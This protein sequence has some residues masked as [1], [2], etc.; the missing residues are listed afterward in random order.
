MIKRILP[1]YLTGWFYL[2]LLF[3][4]AIFC[5]ISTGGLNPANQSNLKLLEKIT[6]EQPLLNK[7]ERLAE[8]DILTLHSSF[9]EY[10]VTDITRLLSF[11]PDSQIVLLG[12]Q[13]K[14][15]IAKLNKHLSQRPR[16][17][18]IIIDSHSKSS[19]NPLEISYSMLFSGGLNWFRFNEKSKTT[20]SHSAHFIFT[21]L[22][23][24]QRQ[25]FPLLW[26][27][28]GKTYLSLL[29]EVLQQLSLNDKFTLNQQW[30]LSLSN[31]KKTVDSEKLSLGF[32][33]EVFIASNAYKVNK[34]G[35]HTDDFKSNRLKSDGLD[36][37]QLSSVEQFINQ[38]YG[39]KV[40]TYP[41]PQY[42]VIIITDNALKSNELVKPLL[43]KL[44]KE[45]YLSQNFLTIIFC[46][47][48]A[49]VGF[50]LIWLIQSLSL[51]Q[52]LISLVIY[53][54][55]LFSLQ[56][57][58]FTQQQWLEILP[59]FIIIFGTWG[60]SLAYYQEDKL[61]STALN[62]QAEK[63][64]S[65]TSSARVIAKY[66]ATNQKKQHYK[67]PQNFSPTATM[68]SEL[69]ED[70]A[71]TLFI[72]TPAATKTN[73]INH[74]LSIESLGRYQIEGILGRGAMGIVYQGVDPKINRHVA[75]KTLRLSD[76]IDPSQYREAKER[77]FREAQTAGGLSHAHIVTIYDVGEENKLGYIAMDL[78]TGAPLSL[79]TQVGQTLPIPLVYQLLIQITDAL[80]YAHTKNVVHRDI[81]PA[82]IIY[83]DD[84]LKVTVTDFGIAYVSDQSKT[85]TGIIMGSPYYMSP[86][87]ILGLK[88]DGR[89]DIFSL[90]VTFYQLLSGH[91]PFKG[92]SIA[93]VAY[94]ITKAKPISI[95]Q[96]NADLP[97]SALRITNKAMHKDIEKRYQSMAEFKSALINAL[98]RDY[99]ITAN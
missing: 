26:Q 75:I 73:T 86:E 87:Q 24:N 1:I 81:K 61:F 34:Y 42:K 33:G 69:T 58:M 77:F 65:S 55:L 36:N 5:Y 76:D 17:N 99:K 67:S 8:T 85:R 3:W 91:L 13:S 79:F 89:S 60:L 44:T 49:M 39:A 7:T 78:L 48:L 27:Y 10:D 92:E 83:D 9:D 22:L 14:A 63:L 32:F 23:L 40:T 37:Q 16:K 47:L 28:Q 96:H 88:V 19:E 98:K 46:W 50:A 93:T 56:C 66:K 52:Q 11:H 35:F 38:H 80:A 64:K 30:Q 4:I 57:F 82:N 90:G 15:F 97:A 68:T 29:G 51:K 71:Q 94:Q 41:N 31:S 6:P 59:V 12:R 84:L 25:S 72:N 18:K 53:T 95:N 20:Q 74:H 70:L 43:L 62:R 21:P 54:L 45:E 2:I